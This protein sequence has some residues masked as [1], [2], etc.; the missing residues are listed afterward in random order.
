V[1]FDESLGSDHAAPVWTWSPSRLEAA[2]KSND[3]TATGYMVD[4]AEKDAWT[5]RC[6][7]QLAGAGPADFESKAGLDREAETQVAAMKAALSAVFKPRRVRKGEIQKWWNAD[8]N[9]AVQRAKE[10]DSAHE[11]TAAHHRLRQ[12]ICKAKR[13]WADTIMAKAS[14]NDI[15]GFVNWGTGKAR[16]PPLRRVRRTDGT[17]A[18]SPEDKADVF[19]EA[20]FPADRPT[21]DIIQPDDPP[22][23]PTQT[24]MDFMPNKLAEALT[25][26][27][28][29]SAPGDDGNSYRLLKWLVAGHAAHVLAFLNACI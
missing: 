19:Y 8:C 12:V 10:A 22:P 2:D 29:V 27:S 9:H 7:E 24:F 17:F 5:A 26:T 15:W 13:K 1:T 14:G 4:P 25:P 23:R 21:V 16:K 20:Y 11:R 28:N 6:G 3:P 18:T